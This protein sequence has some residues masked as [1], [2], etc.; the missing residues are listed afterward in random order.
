MPLQTFPTDVYL[1]TKVIQVRSKDR[2]P[3]QSRSKFDFTYK[4]DE[5][6]ENVVAIEVIGWS[7][8]DNIVPTFIGRYDSILGNNAS[9]SVRSGVP[10]RRTFTIRVYATNNI[11]FLDLPCDMEASNLAT[12]DYSFCNIPVTNL[13]GAIADIIDAAL[14]E[15]GDVNVNSTNTAFSVQLDNFR[16]AIMFWETTSGFDNAVR[17]QMILTDAAYE[18]SDAAGPVLGF[19][20]GTVTE[21]VLTM[22]Y[23]GVA[24]GTNQ[25]IIAPYKYNIQYDRFVNVHLK[26]VTEF[27]PL[28][29]IYLKRTEFQRAF[30]Q[31]RLDPLTRLI[32]TSLRRLKQLGI[33]LT[34]GDDFL[35]PNTASS[36]YELVFEVTYA[37][38]VTNPPSWIRHWFVF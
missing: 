33:R 5:E 24:S 7:I 34:I 13:Q 23:P 28:T 8:P 15:Y 30:I 21:S 27:D 3:D 12:Y 16:L 29:Q 32:P 38:P 19:D 2:V 17:S 31:S 22:A 37:R 26:E 9:G 1:D 25:A 36:E 6:I 10:G 14:T 11:D 18:A 35:P 4:L 20:N